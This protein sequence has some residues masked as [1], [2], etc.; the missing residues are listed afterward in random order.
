MATPQNGGR[1]LPKRFSAEKVRKM[2]AD[3]HGTDS[4]DLEVESSGS[5]CNLSDC[6][7]ESDTDSATSG[8]NTS[9]ASNARSRQEVASH[10]PGPSGERPA[11]R[12]KTSSNGQNVND[13]WKEVKI[14]LDLETWNNFRF[15][16]K[17]GRQPGISHN[18]DLDPADNPSPLRCLKT[19]L[20][21]ALCDYIITSI[22]D[23]AN[24][25]VQKNTQLLR[26]AQG[27]PHGFP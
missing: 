9:S 21:D 24:L 12:A 8:P 13:G 17:N 16:P 5:D 20:T 4:D 3:M 7:E 14:D 27:M 22:N 1:A 10:Q 2:F 23:F 18:L 25:Q 6:D 11:K 26:N 15:L 19:L